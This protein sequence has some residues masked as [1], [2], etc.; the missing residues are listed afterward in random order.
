MKQLSPPCNPQD[1]SRL[2]IGIFDSGL[3][4]LTVLREIK[5]ALPHEHLIYFADSARAPYGAKSAAMIEQ[6]CVE[7]T[8]FLEA[9]GIKVLVVACHTASACALPHLHERF[10]LPILGVVDPAVD[11]VLATTV[12]GRIAVLATRATVL[13]GVYSR[14]IR[15]RLAHAEIF[16]IPCPL[17]VPLVEE[18]YAQ[19]RIAQ[20]TVQEQLRPLKQQRVD[21]L[22]L[23]CTHYPC[24]QHWI[25]KYS[26]LRTT[27]VDPA[28]T[29]AETLRAYLAERGWLHPQRASTED[30]FFVSDDPQR[31][32]R[33]SQAFLGQEIRQVHH[34][35]PLS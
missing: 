24:L 3:G 2:S 34:R 17:F 31:F 18:G 19:S 29:F 10:S 1:H 26:S 9:L 11:A 33:L 30:T 14:R 20:L 4:G 23:G 25:Q 6:Y 28:Q 22:L 12:S 16:E 8:S 35:K 7:N 32:L 15:Q 5:R 21:T 13:S 27:I